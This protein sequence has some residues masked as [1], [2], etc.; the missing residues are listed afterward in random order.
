MTDGALPS[1]INI[2]QMDK[3]PKDPAIL[4]SAL[5]MYLRDRE[6]DSLEALCY[7]YDEDPEKIKA[8]LHE[9]GFDYNE[10]QM[11]FKGR[12]ARN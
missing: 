12:K 5:N 4:V 2:N 1:V 11:Q 6:F 10:E 3:L 7:C 9:A 8:Y